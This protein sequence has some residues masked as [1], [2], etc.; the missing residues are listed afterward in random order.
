MKLRSEDLK[1]E[2]IHCLNYYSKYY[3]RQ[4]IDCENLY[5]SK[6]GHLALFNILALFEN[7]TKSTL[8]DFDD[9]F[10]NLNLKLK[11]ENL[12]NEIE[13]NFLNDRRI[14]IRR[15]RNI[16]AHA[17]LS[18]YDLV[19][20]GDEITF[21]FIE[22]ETCLILYDS[23]SVIISGIILKLLNHSLTLSYEIDVDFEIQSLNFTFITRSPEELIRFKGIKID[24]EWSKL[25]EA[26]K[27]R[28]VEN[29]S[30]VNVL[31][32]IFR[33]LKL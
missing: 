19:I 27:Y 22:N 13:L 25:D 28:L 7:V 17:N 11:N 14:G 5:K 31:S 2:T 32:E 8:N 18:K 16:L 15:I 26:T 3:C 33:G 10:Y 30:D 21:P 6:K 23:L 9:T 29:S 20:E 12:I 1:K 24:A 4:F